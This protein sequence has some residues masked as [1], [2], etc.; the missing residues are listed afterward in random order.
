MTQNRGADPGRSGRGAAPTRSPRRTPGGAA[1]ASGVPQ[2]G[3]PR[4]G[5]PRSGAPRQGTPKAG[6]T[7]ARSSGAPR[8]GAPRTGAPRTGAPRTGTPR[9]GGRG[10]APA[11][12]AA[13]RPSV[14]SSAR[15]SR[16]ARATGPGGPRGPRGPFGPRGPQGP[17]RPLRLSRANPRRRAR[18]IF[19]AILFVFTIFAGQLLRIQAF[20]ASAT[21]EAAL[22][23]RTVRTQTPAMRGQILDMNGQVLADS[24]ER[25][26]IAADP[27]II[28]EYTAKVDGVRRKVGVTRAAA[29]LAPLL[30]MSSSALTKLFTRSGTR[31]VVIKKEVNPAVYREIRALGV[32][33]ITGE[34]TAR[35]IYPTSMA[36]GQLVGFVRPD[37]QTGA[38]GIEQMLDKTLAGTPGV[39]V[40]QRARDG[41]VIP[42]SQREDKPVVNG[43]DV[44]LTIDADLQ[45]YAQNALAKQVTAVGAES[46]TAVVLEVAT[47]KVRAAA[48]Y[49]TFDP[50]DL[51][52]AKSSAL[53]NYAFNDAFEPGSTGK[54]MTMAAA[55][56][57][58]VITPDTGV[59]VPSRLP[60]AGTSF[61]DN[62]PHGVENMTATGVLAKSSNMGTM[63]IGERVSPAIMEAY[64]RKFGIG[65]KTPVGFP[66]ESAG[67]LAGAKDWVSTR[68]Y[69]IL[70]GQGYAVTAI[71]QAGVFQTVANKG[72]RVPPSLIEGTVNESGTLIPTAPTTPSRVIKTDTAVKLSRML[73]E[74]TGENG[75][76]SAARIKGYRVAGKTGTAD[77]YDEKL[78]RYNGFTASFIGFAPA[79]A[80]KY[81]VAVFIQKPSAGMF[82]GALAGPVFNQVMTYLLER[83][84]A[85]PST[86][87]TLDYHVWAEKP[88]S[89]DDPAVISN[90]R[91]KRDGL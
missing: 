68:R 21:Q 85:P 32:P 4:S 18:V 47:G 12:G 26:T 84:G 60:R 78:G 5:A 67:L 37:D 11:R 1:T 59:I 27:K 8:T 30:G 62:E 63:L 25:F 70:F 74:V 31:Y 22:S 80:P 17:A 15:P 53:G 69:T 79:E 91:A 28:P 87:S 90:A 20:D 49:P 16:P 71:Q 40:A 61:K 19:V 2:P 38:G 56:E 44:K 24:V 45:W 72:V 36:L 77:R 33:G 52:D 48:S 39:S 41:Y 55:L 64:Y 89:S 14:R 34:R 51:A 13:A 86:K 65:T 82:G 29:D 10:P 7:A 50:N 73:E 3:A 76:A 81:V 9:T 83:T 75:T 23:K 35:R 43:R 88:L 57:Q 42:G 58:G 66:G 54:L 6:G 46:G